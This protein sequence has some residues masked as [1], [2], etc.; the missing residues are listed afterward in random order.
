V[1]LFRVVFAF[2]RVTETMIDMTAIIEP[3]IYVLSPIS[4]SVFSPHIFGSPT[5]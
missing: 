2:T 5:F 3:W 1:M 4:T